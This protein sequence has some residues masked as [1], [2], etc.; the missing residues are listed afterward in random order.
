[1]AG[2]RHYP[3]LAEMDDVELVALSELDD[4]K[5]KAGVEKFGFPKT[6]ADYQEMVETEKP[7]AVYALMPPQHIF[8]VMKYLLVNGHNTFTEKPPALSTFQANVLTDIIDSNGNITMVGYQRKWVPLVRKMRE[9]IEANGPIDHFSVGFHKNSAAGLYYDGAIDILTCDASHMVDCMMWL[10]G[11]D[12]VDV[13]SAVRSSTSDGNCK[14]N[15]LVVFE[16]DRT[17]FFSANWNSGTRFL[18]LQIHGNAC[19][20]MSDVEH[21]GTYYDADNPD[22]ITVTAEEA[23]GSEVDHRVGGF[24]DQSRHFIDCVKSGEQPI[25][26]FPSATKTVELVD[27]IYECSMI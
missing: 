15:A 1:M 8:P 6:Y 3:A 26:S 19:V 9:M 17:G 14:Y 5:M 20:A 13:V 22:G 2:S 11:S 23:A 24:F 12:P 7:D 10:G 27:A 4:E 16:G 25:G 18:E 21:T